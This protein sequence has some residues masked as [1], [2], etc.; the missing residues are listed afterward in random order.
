[1][2]EDT[3][4]W[5]VELA[6]RDLKNHPHVETKEPGPFKELL[7]PV[8]Y[9]PFDV[10]YTYYTGKSRG[11]HCMPRGE[12]MRHMLIGENLGL[13]TTR[14]IEI[15]RGWEHIFCT[16]QIIQHHTVSLKEVNYLFPLYVY[17]DTNNP[18]QSALE[19][20]RRPNFSQIFLNAVN[21]QLGYNP[22]PEAIF[23][24]IYAVFHS[25]TYR[26]HYA[27][28]LKIDFPRVPLTSNNELFRELAAYGEEL[29]A[30]HLMQS[31]KLDNLITQFIERG[32]NRVIDAGHPKFQQG[33]VVINKKGDR[34]TSVPEHVWNFYVGGYQ[35]CQK[36]LKDCKRRTLNDE[37]IQHYQCIVVALNETIE[38]M[39][40][41][42]AA[43]PEWPIQ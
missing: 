40:K 7:A 35:I 1:M 3:R 13:S 11:F 8:L 10:R 29:V 9:R 42:D 18:Q 36:W 19:E 4:D 2:G 15:G 30:L 16:K 5:K 34:F 20:Q 32:G 43:I 27:E 37:D 38:L 26:T 31:P 12:V 23:Y 22:T 6:Q 17:P 33:D 39:A 21:A 14:S 41:I 28:F 25:P 24:Y